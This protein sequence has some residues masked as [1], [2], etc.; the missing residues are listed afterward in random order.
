MPN[1]VLAKR[2]SGSCDG[3]Q[4][5]V[6]TK[7]AN[8]TFFVKEIVR[9]KTYCSAIEVVEDKECICECLLKAKD[10]T[11]YQRYS[12]NTCTCRCNDDVSA[13]CISY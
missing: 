5:C 13:I 12:P 1:A 4:R 9:N 6:T 7:S 10:C 3:F 11:A 8:T 2:C